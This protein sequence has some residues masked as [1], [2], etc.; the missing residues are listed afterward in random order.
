MPVDSQK[1]YHPNPPSPQIDEL[2]AEDLTGET[3]VD[4]RK[5]KL[6][7]ASL[8]LFTLVIILIT[9]GSIFFVS[10][11]SNQ[12]SSLR[13]VIDILFIQNP[14]LSPYLFVVQRE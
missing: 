4:K 9:V 13:K 11:S 1:L 6:L 10:S 14:R 2:Q 12:G 8:T 3:L 5:V 7:A